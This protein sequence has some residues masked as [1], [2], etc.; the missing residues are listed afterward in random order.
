[1]KTVSV[2]MPCFNDGKYINESIDCILNQEYKN[3]ELIIIDDGSTDTETIDILD[4]ISNEKIKILKTER[5]GPAGARN[6]GIEH[7]TGEY[8][9]PLDSDDLIDKTYISKAVN[10]I[11]N[12]KDVGI[13]YCEA[14]LFGQATGKW[15]LKPYTIENMLVDNV[16]FV[17]A[18]FRK[19]DWEK[20]KGFDEDLAYGLEDY[21]FWLSI[22]ELGRE[23]VQIPEIL[24]KYRIKPISRNKSFEKDE[25]NIKETYKIIYS[26]HKELYKKY[27]EQY[28]EALRNRL[29]DEI[30]TNKRKLDKIKNIPVIRQ[31]INNKNIKIKLKKLISK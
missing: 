1:M 23:V 18:M 31:I 10:I 7:A 29:I 24:F 28:V 20:V 5:L 25:N 11:S 12:N 27:N 14:E 8:I 17:T 6:K 26:N 21:S 30:Y 3:I 13:V 2:I 4:N 16:I 15:E 22:I 9:L 19:E